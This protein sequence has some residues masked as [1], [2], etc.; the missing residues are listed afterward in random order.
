MKDLNLLYVF[1]ALW[2]DR[3]VTIAAESLDVTQG[4]VS[5]ALKRMR[6]EYGDKLFML[7]GRRM[8]PTAMATSIAP[9]LLEALNAIRKT[10]GVQTS[11]DAAESTRSFTIRTRDVGE[12]VVLPNLFARMEDVAPRVKIN[13]MFAPIE[14]TVHGLSTG[15]MDVALGYLPALER[16]IH[17]KVLFKQRY[18]CVMRNDHPLANAELTLKRFLSQQHLLVEYAGSGHVLLERA[19]IDAGAKDRIRVRMP[20]YLAAPHLVLRSD[21]IWTCPESLVVELRKHFPLAVKPL[22]MPMGNFDVALYWHDRFHKDPANLWFRQQVIECV[23][24]IQIN[25]LTAPRTSA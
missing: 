15:R 2:R 1:E 4:A 20:Q 21:L 10:T 24:D 22:P 18:L 9:S 17:K 19:L 7:A 16:N 23:H 8:E 12:V 25:P 6:D 3:S 11:F 14:E 5:S 13:V